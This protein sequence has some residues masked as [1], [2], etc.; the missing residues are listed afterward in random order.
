MALWDH[1]FVTDVAYTT[2]AYV[3]TTPSW[4]AACSLLLQ[5]RP[6]DLMAPFRYADLGCGNGLN[7]MIAAATNPNAEVWG[8]DFNPT[9]TE[10]G[11]ALAAAAGLTNIRFEEMSFEALATGAAELP[12][13]F[14]LMV[15]HGVLSWIS[16]EN[17]RH[18]AGAFERWLRPG[19]LGYL[20]YNVSTGWAAMEPIRLLMQ[21][22]AE[23]GQRRTDQEVPDIVATLE[24]LK[25]GGALFFQ[26]HPGLEARLDQL[27]RMDH[28][29]IAHEF[30]NRDWHP[31]MF[32][33]VADAMNEARTQY[34]GSATLLENI[35][36]LSVPA[37][38]VPIL[39]TVRDPG[40]RETMRD[41]ASAKSFRRD[42][43][44]RGGE[45]LPVLEQSAK[46]EALGLVW[47]GK[48]AENPIQF[49]TPFGTLTGQAE[50]Y[51][52]M[53]EALRRGPV[54]VGQLRA[55]P[56]LVGRPLGDFI[57][58]AMLLIGAGYAFPASPAAG[59]AETVA[60]TA[61]LNA[62]I[63]ARI[64]LGVDLP[65]F[66]SPVAGCSVA[67]AVLEAL[68]IGQIVEG[69]A[70]ALDPLTDAVLKD[71]GQS[72]RSLMNEGELVR[73]PVQARTMVSNTMRDFIA[74]RLTLFQTLGIV[75][76]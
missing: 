50:F 38:V 69:M 72:G 51:G 57:Q 49:A 20:S 43:W 62:A 4:L 28:R 61:R 37:N 9:H 76:A 16:L 26:A 39:N 25:A 45:P 74:G 52:P 73:D 44:R 60:A 27:K 68:A 12:G 22:L 41:L 65:C 3:E 46:L 15:S 13:R 47:T 5:Q 2:N 6:T 10:N 75:P 33:D 67:V 66:A 54:T 29:Y 58:A 23:L 11:R 70:P 40:I 24:Q 14:D 31:V 55:I 35:D 59:L 32:A 34:I 17:R 8:F 30:L 36:A 64:R 63:L 18:L 1:G 19:G 21:Q 56:G 7:A 71:L 53:T 48:A 42:L